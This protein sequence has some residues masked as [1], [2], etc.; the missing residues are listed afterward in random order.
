MGASLNALR[1]TSRTIIDHPGLF[2]SG[3]CSVL[4]LI[5]GTGLSVL[6]LGS[7]TL[8]AVIVLPVAFVGFVTVANGVRTNTNP[9]IIRGFAAGVRTYGGSLIIAYLLI[10]LIQ[11]CFTFVFIFGMTQI[12]IPTGRLFRAPMALLGSSPYSTVEAALIII[13]LL[14][15]FL[16]LFLLTLIQQFLDVAVVIGSYSG[17]NAL[18]KAGELIRTA[19][20]SIIGYII[21]RGS[22]LLLGIMP[23]V[24][25]FGSTI[26]DSITAAAV[27][28]WF[29]PFIAFVISMIFHVC[30]YRHREGLDSS[31]PIEKPTST[32]SSQLSND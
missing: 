22:I 17:P 12:G 20:G 1:D 4:I 10:Y 21:T 3:L 19:P 13:A 7:R 31:Q 30:Y 27:V 18:R 29:L 16:I 2:I 26:P 28:F 6:P 15:G 5:L 25:I 9:G 23:S 24:F 32:G 8:Y 14:S 11:F